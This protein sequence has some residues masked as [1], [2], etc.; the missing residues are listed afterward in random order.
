MAVSLGSVCCY[1]HFVIYAEPDG[2][3][4]TGLVGPQISMR[5]Q[6]S[7][8]TSL[9]LV[10]VENKQRDGETFS[11]VDRVSTEGSN[12]YEGLSGI[13][14]AHASGSGETTLILGLNF[15]DA[16][17]RTSF[18]SGSQFLQKM[19]ESTSYVD[20]C[21]NALLFLRDSDE[22]QTEMHGD[23][24]SLNIL[25]H[26]VVFGESGDF[27]RKTKGTLAGTENRYL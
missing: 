3:E 22:Q 16:I 8:S 5:D 13:A 12:V 11:E 27:E 6:I 18:L 9:L 1:S 10:D 19:W 4:I 15:T 14:A 24:I 2:D 25:V 26:Y 7:E 20:W 23:E 17:K 21:N